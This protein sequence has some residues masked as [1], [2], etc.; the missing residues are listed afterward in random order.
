MSA[1]TRTLLVN[2]EVYSSSD[3]F[4]TA[5]MI[6]DGVITWVGDD[7]G[8]RVH[9]DL[10]HRVVD[11][12]GAFVAPGFV[13][14]HVHA[15]S[16]GL[17]LVGLDLSDTRS[18]QDVLDAVER[19]AME[20]TTGFIYGH[21]WDETMWSDPRLPSRSQIDQAA[22]GQHVYMSRIDVHSA[23]VS[24]SLASHSSHAWVT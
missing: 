22:R 16:T 10:A 3:P 12:E 5:L 7:A 2:A 1:S 11:L 6:D 4:A 20:S 13:D 21:G 18:A 17:R 23:L 15:T 8:A 9:T 14:S 19:R 24:T